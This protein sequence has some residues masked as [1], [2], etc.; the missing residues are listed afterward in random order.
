MSKKKTAF[1]NLVE[2]EVLWKDTKRWLGMPL[3]FT[4][5][6]VDANRLYLKRGFLKTEMDEILLY[7]ILDIRSTRTL[8]QK[9]FGVGT[10][11]LYSADQ[12]TST[13]ELKN[14]KQPD[15][16]R[17]FL[18]NLIEKQRTEKGITGR[19]IYG[20][21]GVAMRDTDGDGVPDVPDHGGDFGHDHDGDFGPGPH[22]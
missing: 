2:D 15:K 10:L 3:T 5:Y 11:T 6:N 13:L 21:M 12:S 18:S 4:K 9:L 7:R 20:T 17:K 16:V 19:E 8:G 14:I 1:D 22:N